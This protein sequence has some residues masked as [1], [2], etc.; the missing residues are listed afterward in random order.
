[1]SAK[2][3]F[4]RCVSKPVP[5]LLHVDSVEGQF[6]IS[7]QLSFDFNTLALVEQATGLSVL[8]DAGRFFN[9]PSVITTSALFWAAVQEYQPEYEGLEGLKAVRGLLT[10]GTAKQ[11]LEACGEAF[12]AQLPKEQAE[13]LRVILAK[14]KAG[15]KPAD[16]IPGPVETAAAV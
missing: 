10:I 2:T 8:T 16:P 4:R 15:E 3:P 5:F 12:I 1:M 14:V 13:R 6:D 9:N 11:A 7:F